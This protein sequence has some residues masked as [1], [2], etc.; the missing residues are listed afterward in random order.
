MRLPTR[1][2]LA[3]DAGSR[4]VKLLLLQSDFGRL[5]L[6]RHEMIDLRA[7]GLVSAEEVQAHLRAVVAELGHPPLALIIPEHLASSHVIDLPPGAE[8]EVRRQIGDEAV[9]L[10]GVSE[11]RIIYDFAR[12]ESSA[13]NRQNFW[14]T[15]CQEDNIRGQILQLGVEREDISE[16]TTSA[17]ALITAHRMASPSASRAALLHMG[18]QTTVLAGVQNGQGAFAASVQMGGDFL[19]RAAARA[20]GVSE[21]EAESLKR[22]ENLFKGP[23]ACPELIEAVN[24]WAREVIRQIGEGF[25]QAPGG[26]ADSRQVEIIW[27]GG[28]LDQPGLL[29][30]LAGL[31]LR[32]RPWPEDTVMDGVS[33]PPGFEMAFGTALQ[34]LGH[35]SQPVSLLPED[36]RASWQKRLGRQRLEL[37]SIALV[38]LC[39]AALALGTWRKLA[40]I[41]EKQYLANKV[42]TAQES[43][44][45]NEALA[46]E[47]LAQYQSLRPI[48]AA[49]QN[50]RDTLKTLALLQ[51]TRTNKNLWHLILADQRTYFSLPALDTPASSNRA[52]KPSLTL[53]LIEAA[54]LAGITNRYPTNAVSPA[55]PGCIAELCLPGD[56]EPVRRALQEIVNQLKQNPLFSKADL[57][58][59]DL[60]RNLADPRLLS[61]DRHFVLSLDFAESDFHRP[62]VLPERPNKSKKGK[63]I[64]GVTRGTGKGD[65]G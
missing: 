51:Q 18:A 28:G 7:E 49:Q 45:K 38:F 6:L 9:K 14:V 59:E 41:A 39:A 36:Y 32:L 30:H 43:A 40:L 10:S 53:D 57:L 60:R 5:R 50:T 4:R 26:G 11:S 24:G 21:D 63:T 61:N 55:K 3:I 25:K 15:L 64:R 58:S 19:T 29:E 56:S 23:K 42:Q 12:L 1:R 22:S 8:T 65:G 62:V 48:L 17:N 54:R 35:S 37:A 52:A 34:A 27:S 2:V 16:I 20:R 44:E 46:A 33:C 47:L 31:G 13:P